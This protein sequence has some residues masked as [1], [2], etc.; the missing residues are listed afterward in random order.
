MIKLVLN[1]SVHSMFSEEIGGVI[2]VFVQSILYG[3]YSATFVHCIRWLTFNDDGWKLRE[4][5]NWFMILMTTLLFIFSTAN[6]GA[7][8]PLMFT[9][10]GPST[11]DFLKLDV[12]NV[13]LICVVMFITLIFWQ[14]GFEFTTYLITDG[15]LVCL[16]PIWWVE[17]TWITKYFLQIY[18]CWIIYGKS[19]L[20]I[21]LPLLLVTA[22]MLFMILDISSNAIV[23]TRKSWDIGHFAR[24]RYYF[25]VIPGL[26]IA[27]NIYA[28][29]ML[30]PCG[31]CG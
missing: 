22:N 2:A 26:S 6:L 28:T 20:V 18:R 7:T 24:F 27:I 10:L 29:C 25:A 30:C 3:L 21:S 14:L 31:S 13:C 19:R 16:L 12:T 15:I 8:V 9:I 23:I 17:V 5:M 1:F 4:K 11:V